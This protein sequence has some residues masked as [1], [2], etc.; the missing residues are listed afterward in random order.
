MGLLSIGGPL[1]DD[2]HEVKL[3][4]ADIEPLSID[5]IITIVKSDCPQIIMIGHS[6]SSSVHM[7]VLRLSEKLKATFPDLIIVYGGVHPTYNWE[8]TLCRCAAIDI[9]VRGEGEETCVL[10]ANALKNKKELASING[11]AF[12]QNS[13]PIC[14]A[15][16]NIIENLD[17][18]RVG[19]ELIDFEK[20]SYWGG[21]RAV[22][23]QFSRGC[24]HRCSYC[25]Q[26]LFWK[27]WRHRDPVKFAKEM[28][29]LHREHG[30]ELINFA[31]ELPTGSQ[32]AWKRFLN[33]LIEEN[34]SLLLV[35]STRAGDIIRDKDLLP[36]YKKAGVVRFLLGIEC[37][38]EQVLSKIRKDSDTVNDMLAITLLRKNNIV[39]M[40]S[41]VIGFYENSDRD[42]LK[43]LIQLLRYDPDQ[44]QLIYA[45]PHNW[46]DFYHDVKENAI[47]QENLNLWDYKHQVMD[48]SNVPSWRVF[49]WFKLIE[50]I[51]QL[52]PKAI[53]RHF[54]K[55]DS[56]F[57]YAMRWYSSV[58]RRVWLH[59]VLEFIF[60]TKQI[61]HN[62]PS[63][64]KFMDNQSKS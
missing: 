13:V 4:D 27:K 46:T 58:G 10:L 37:Y 45:T 20:Y 30:V 63:L 50:A 64:Q 54:F 11:I 19:W 21:K 15:D 7:T 60:M 40:V 49:A 48:C 47:V 42:F 39:S 5:N 8:N 1:I 12:R 31:D 38:N 32:E 41:C 34:V 36:L 3:L 35:G 14:T 51:L 57:T 44:I 29:W 52:R 62:K 22:V 9:I 53:L 18:Y 26:R 25:G 17:S 6:G 61:K 55:K 28:A 2:G 59:E 16:A 33:A 56:N 23:V 43:T 24:K